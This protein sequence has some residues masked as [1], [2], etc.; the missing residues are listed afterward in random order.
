MPTGYA[1]SMQSK[2]ISRIVEES[3][4]PRLFSVLA[5]EISPGDL[6]S[7]LLSV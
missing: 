4:L 7:L 2:I 3:G 5:E 1:G 6:Q